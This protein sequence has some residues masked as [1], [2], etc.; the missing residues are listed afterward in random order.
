VRRLHSIE[1]IVVGNIVVRKGENVIISDENF[2]MY[3]TEDIALFQWDP[4]TPSNI[5]KDD[6]LL[7]IHV[8]E[9]KGD[10]EIC[11]IPAS[12]IPD[13]DVGWSFKV[14]QSPF[15][16]RGCDAYPPDAGIDS[17]SEVSKAVVVDRGECTF[18]HKVRTA[19][20]VGFDLVIVVDSGLTA[21]QRFIPSLLT[22]KETSVP[23]D[24]LLPLVLVTGKRDAGLIKR[25]DKLRIAGMKKRERRMVV[26]GGMSPY[27]TLLILQNTSRMFWSS[28]DDTLEYRFQ[29]VNGIL[30]L[31]VST[32]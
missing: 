27:L 13:L 26:R 4:P 9:R 20:Q 17:D 19:K 31:P 3:K 11:A 7:S 24:E 18:L 5:D 16:P 8:S 15:N 30:I 28:P 22:E 1:L 6:V 14:Y 12:G 25:A 32:Q 10:V 29:N 21:G 2:W 23:M